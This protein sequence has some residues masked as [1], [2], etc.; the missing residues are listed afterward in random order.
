[1]LVTIFT[2]SFL[3]LFFCPPIGIEFDI[4]NLLS[5]PS[6]LLLV[7]VFYCC[8]TN[9][10][11]LTDWKNNIVLSYH[12]AGHNP[13]WGAHWVICLVS[14]SWN[15]GVS[16]L[17]SYPEALG[18]WGGAH[19]SCWQ[20]LVPGTEVPVFLLAV[21]QGISSA[22]RGCSQVPST[23]RCSL[24]LQIQQ[25]NT[26]ILSDLCNFKTLCFDYSYND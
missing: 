8:L 4:L 25:Q 10:H 3:K 1:M 23:R 17:S 18:L 19:S 20:T 14:Q 16:W 11:R 21:S 6:L 12:S 22:L 13:G 7:L 2:S 24:A 5:L 15:Q 9:C 26:P